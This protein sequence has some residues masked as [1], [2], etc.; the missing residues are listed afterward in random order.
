MELDLVEHEWNIGAWLGYKHPLLLITG[1]TVIN[2]WIVLGVLLLVIVSMRIALGYRIG[3]H[4]VYSI[5]RFLMDLTTQSIGSFSFT[6][7]AFISAVF[8]YILFCNLIALVPGI[9]EPTKDLSTTLAL[10]IITFMHRQWITI[11]IHGLKA[12]ISEYF[13]PFFI[14]F[15]LNIVG[16]FASIVSVSFR[17]F[18]NIFG[19]S[20][21]TSLYFQAVEKS[22][23]LMVGMT[24]M[25]LVVIL[26][27]TVFEGFLQAFV[28]TMLTLTYLSISIQGEGGH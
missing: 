14:M 13:E 24:G 21:I 28:F 11:R 23:L 12:Y 10:G 4:I 3:R 8:F 2:T 19:G 6:H 7:F 1:T 9:E 26:F 17:L 22:V 20:I 27:F 25:H 5:M 18:G 16:K 15:P